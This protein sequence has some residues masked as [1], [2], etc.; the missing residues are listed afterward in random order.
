MALDPA[1]L[2][3]ALEPTFRGVAG[4]VRDAFARPPAPTERKADG[5]VVTR[6]D[7]ELEARITTALLRLDAT[8]GVIA[9]ES[10]ILREGTP[11]W[12]V[13]ALDGSLN[14]S[15]RIPL[16]VCQAV[17]MDGNTPQFAVIYDPLHDRLAWAAAGAGAWREGQR[18]RVA[19]RPLEDAL[20]LVDI[21]R[22]GAFVTNPEAIPKLRRAVLRLRS[23][24]CV[25]LHFL[26]VAAG[27]ADAFLG[28][29][30]RPSP[31]HDVGP[32]TLFV[33]EAGGLVTNLQGE[34]VI[35]DR[36]SILAAHHELHGAIRQVVLR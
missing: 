8:W 28:T 14:F 1:A 33:R 15:R 27:E 32:G 18:L 24:G 34:D 2:R 4:V 13:D 26:S 22:S 3:L 36:R 16:F 19:R 31:L 12:Y 9:E 7:H 23:L 35:P 10:G 21:A 20:L 6:L 5:T 29:R 25:G 30:R 11:T 17:L